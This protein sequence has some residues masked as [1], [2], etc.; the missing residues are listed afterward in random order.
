[1]LPIDAPELHLGAQI[2]VPDFVGRRL[3]RLPRPTETA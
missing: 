2:L 1:M 3:E